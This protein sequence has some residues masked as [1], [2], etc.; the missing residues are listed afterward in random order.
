MIPAGGDKTFY[1]SFKKNEEK[2][3]KKAKDYQ[4][5]KKK[6]FARSRSANAGMNNRMS[7]PIKD[8]MSERTGDRLQIRCLEFEPPGDGAGLT[9]GLTNAY[10]KNSETNELTIITSEER[11]Q[12]RNCLL[13]TSDAADE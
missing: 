8:S 11:E 5:T 3:F 9:I 2:A 4:D 7:Y 13:Y 12:I 1:D 10:K 6:K